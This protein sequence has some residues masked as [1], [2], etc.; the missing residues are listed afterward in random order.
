[1]GQVQR[2]VTRA[3][4]LLGLALVAAVALSTRVPAATGSA[5]A[6]VTISA[7][8]NGELSVTPAGPFARGLGL[9]PGRARNPAGGTVKVHNSTGSA[10]DVRVRV[11][12]SIRDLDAI[13]VVD[14]SADGEQVYSGPLAGLET[15]STG[16]FRL[17]RGADGQVT[18]RAS[19]P[20]TVQSGYEARVADLTLEFQ[21]Q[22]AVA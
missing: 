7:N 4:F 2:W 16:S 8:S 3:G 1:M 22:P 13:L 18:V 15:W 11:L 5:G 12:R 17:G 21:L 9:E 10:A 6:D 14:V 20:S 19:L